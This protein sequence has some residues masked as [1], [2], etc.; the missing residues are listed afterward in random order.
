MD[1]APR[2]PEQNHPAQLLL[3]YDPPNTGEDGNYLSYLLRCYVLGKTC[4][5]TENERVHV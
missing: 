4:Y 3:G 1:V 2:G 5:T